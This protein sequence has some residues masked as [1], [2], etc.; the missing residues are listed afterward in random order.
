M[1][2]KTPFD[3]AAAAIETVLRSYPAA[4][5]LPPKG[6]FHYHQGVFLS[7]VYENYRLCGEERWFSYLK[8]WVDSALDG[9]GRRLHYDELSLGDIQ[10][11]IL[12]FPLYERTKD[13]KYRRALEL[14]MEELRTYPRTEEGGFWHQGGLPD[15][16]WLDGLYMGGPICVMYARRFGEPEFAQTAIHQA[17]LMEEKTRDSRSGLW[18]HACDCAKKAPWADPQTGLSPEFWGRS[19]GWVPVAVLDELDYLPADEPKRGELERLIRELLEALIP[20]QGGDGRWYQVVNKPGEAGNWPENSCTCL[21]TA[22]IC[23]AV[24]TGVLDSR[25]LEN[26]RRAYDGV[27][28]SLKWRENGDAQDLLLGEVCVGTGVGDYRHYCQRPVC[29][30]DLHGMGA[31]LLMCAELERCGGRQRVL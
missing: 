3:Y 16:L 7:G 17:L 24:R 12:F 22:A 8:D 26:A 30:N 1:M 14:L 21:Y 5:D 2:L 15:Q 6:H 9:Q 20:F 11:G 4:A 18:Y 10:P 13:E 27:T 28:A 23:K 19:I 31:F 29:V 25:Y